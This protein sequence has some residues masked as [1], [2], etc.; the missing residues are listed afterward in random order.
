MTIQNDDYLGLSNFD[1]FVAVPIRGRMERFSTEDN[2]FHRYT[3]FIWII[4]GIT[5]LQGASHRQPLYGA[6]CALIPA[7]KPHRSLVIGKPVEYL[8][9]NLRPCLFPAAEIGVFYL[10]PLSI[11]LL[12]RMGARDGQSLEE[13]VEYQCLRLFLNLVHEEISASSF[14]LEF[15]VAESEL[16]R[17]VVEYID[18]HYSEECH[19]QELSEALCYSERHIA[20]IFRG[21]LGLSVHEYLRMYRIFR[22]SI[23]LREQGQTATEAALNCGYQSLSCFY[24]DFKRIFHQP[25][26]EFGRHRISRPQAPGSTFAR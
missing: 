21:D 5:M 25:P 15:P 17:K 18:S 2:H 19:M 1:S 24:T 13:G 14:K 20:R 12:T 9:L 26:A 11:Q 22:A 6:M 4:N 10:S 16:G 23:M 8:S 7:G 3:Q